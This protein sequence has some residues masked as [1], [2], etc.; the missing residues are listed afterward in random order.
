MTVDTIKSASITEADSRPQKTAALEYWSQYLRSI[1]VPLLRAAGTYSPSDQASHLQFLDDYIAPNLGP[2]PTEQH[3]G[4]TTPSSLVCSPLDPS[5]NLTS[6]GS[7]KVR[8]DYD[9]LR[10][11]DRHGPDPFAEGVSK[12]MLH[13]LASVTGADT[14]WLDSLISSVY[15]SPS[16]TEAARV[17][18]PSHIA[19]PPSS[20]GFDLDGS[21]RTLKAYIPTVRKA[22]ATGKPPTQVT[23]EALRALEPLGA[24][25][26]PTLDILTE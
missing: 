2:L 8:F 23:L 24:E 11:L 9:V 4:Y 14:Q 6:S 20:I 26:A 17:K 15:L 22:I 7:A 1:F 25:L 18:M 16:E 21:K 12:Q 10:P 19:V 3:S 13:H 5:I